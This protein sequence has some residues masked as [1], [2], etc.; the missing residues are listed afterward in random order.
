MAITA[1]SYETFPRCPTYGFKSRPN[2]L[3]KI[4]E[5]EGGSERRDRKW[6]EPLHYY[7]G[8]PLGNAK[9]RDMEAVLN[10]YHA[11]GGTHEAFRFKDEVD[12]NS[13]GVEGTIAPGDQPFV[14][15]GGGSYQLVK[16]YVAGSRITVR[17]ILLPKGSTIRVQNNLGAEQVAAR[18]TI[19]EDTG[20]L[21]LLGGFVG[22]PGAWGGEFYVRC[23]FDAPIEPQIINHK[24]VNVA[25]T[26]KELRA[27][28]A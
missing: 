16:Q 9:Q 23:R 28:D 2:Y 20:I 13:C 15:L 11:M 4:A 14:A 18:W 21:T 3:V 6:A 26:L 24:I 8:T 10:F 27:I 1:T 7:E 25:A 5:R 19:N 22:T 17:T 12:Y